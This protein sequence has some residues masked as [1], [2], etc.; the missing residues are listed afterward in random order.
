MRENLEGNSPI[1]IFMAGLP[2]KMA[3]LVAE[4]VAVREEFDLLP[5]AMT[6][7]RH[8][9]TWAEINGQRVHLV[10]YCPNNLSPERVAI[11]FTTPQ[12]VVLNSIDYT[13]LRVPFVMG[14]S[15]GNREEMEGLVRQSRTCAVIAAN[16]DP[17]IIRQQMAI[18]EFAEINPGV[19]KDATVGIIESHQKTKK[20]VSGTA[21]AFR[22]QF[23][24][25]D[26]RPNGRIVS[27][28]DTKIQETLG[29]PD[30]D[31]G[32]AYHWVMVSNP[33]AQLIYHFSTAVRGRSS[34][35]EGT[36]MAAQFLR[37]QICLGVQGQVF[38]MRDVLR[39]GDNQ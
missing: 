38:S 28:R 12:S 27:I 36:L 5:V 17:Q 2:G 32:H 4:A 16:M 29:I 19:F 7:P 14:T 6:S 10:D 25:H 31:S 11:D 35:V 8:K 15:G 22:S 18:D 33:N 9:L 26:A 1:P 21:I 24:S 13:S 20:D 39:G 37:R 3:S 23:E 30:P 34:Y